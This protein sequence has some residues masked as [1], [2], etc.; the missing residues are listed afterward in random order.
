MTP[1]NNTLRRSASKPITERRASPRSY[2]EESDLATLLDTTPHM[3][4]GKVKHAQSPL[5]VGIAFSLD[6]VAA[7]GQTGLA[8]FYMPA[9]VAIPF[10]L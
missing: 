10:T 1:Y 6:K 8:W 5:Y 9:A 2:T 4:Q 3:S 7:N